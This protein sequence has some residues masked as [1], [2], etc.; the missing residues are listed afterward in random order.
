MKNLLKCQEMMIIQSET[1]H[2]TCIIKIIITHQHRLI[3]TNK[4]NYFST[5]FFITY[6]QQKTILNFS[7][8]SLTPSGLKQQSFLKSKP[9]V[10]G[11]WSL[12][13]G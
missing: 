2:I 13:A 8:D 4:C 10:K 1:Y 7:L 12:P 9:Q 11:H 3:M 6:K 5:M